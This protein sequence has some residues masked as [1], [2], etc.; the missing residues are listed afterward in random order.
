MR[1]VVAL[2]EFAWLPGHLRHVR[3]VIRSLS[4]EVIHLNDV[5]MV[6]AAIV[7]A[8]AG[9]PV[10]WHLRSSLPREGL[11]RR[12][13]LVCAAIRRYAAA[14]IAIDEDVAG[15]FQLLDR[16]AIIFNPVNLGALGL[17]PNRDATRVIAGFFGYLRRV[18]G[19]PQ[20]VDAASI[21]ESRGVDVQF[22]VIGGGVH[23]RQATSGLR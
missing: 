7:A 12:S 9:I 1:W 15:S 21:L 6:P 17:A 4:P 10:V 5:V 2:R 3:C 14:T 22:V 18:K 11:D 23:S 16:P 20:I 19:W 8:R 13:R